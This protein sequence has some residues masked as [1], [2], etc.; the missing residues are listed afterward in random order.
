M[1]FD[2]EQGGK[3]AADAAARA[4]MAMG[5]MAVNSQ[6]NK[7]TLFG[8][9]SN[10]VKKGVEMAAGSRVAKKLD[11]VTNR[12]PGIKQA[13]GAL[14]KGTKAAIKAGKKMGKV[15]AKA[16][17]KVRK[18]AIDI[19]TKI[20]KTVNKARHKTTQASLKAAS[21]ATKSV[22]VIG[23]GLSAGIKSAE[24]A[25]KAAERF[26]QKLAANRAALEKS[27]ITAEGRTA[28]TLEKTSDVMER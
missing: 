12:I 7:K 14:K 18:K 6:K 3:Q 8:E 4:A 27:A 19:K 26:E 13:K 21:V 17:R 28:E 23:T 10:T 11:K 22:P 16:G 1:S 20:T 2:A 5:T 9:I 24:K 25:D 15:M